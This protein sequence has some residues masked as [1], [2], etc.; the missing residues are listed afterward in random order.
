MVSFAFTGGK[1]GVGKS[2]LATNVALSLCQAG[3]RA[4]L[5]DADLQL[6][7]LDVMLGCTPSYNLQ[8]VVS[9]QMSLKEILHD[10]PLGL[11]LVSGGSALNGL[12]NAG[13]K[14]MATFLTQLAD[15]SSV[16]DFL[17]FDTGAGVDNRVMTFL[18]LAN[19]VV[20]VTTPDP[21][22]VTDAYATAKVLLKKEPSAKIGVLV[23]FVRN[24]QEAHGVFST[25]NAI[26]RQFLD[27]ELS[28]WG[29]VRADL[30]AIESVRQRRPVVLAQPITEASQ[31]I[32]RVA[33]AMMARRAKSAA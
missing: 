12:M 19:E 1:G 22:S 9:Q 10:G 4:V 8:H 21:T 18:R 2:I 25:L 13:P 5:F 33:Q 30:A 15:L 11:K 20:L 24:E 7:N 3:R 32:Q 14:R 16:A 6:A 17:I 31:D 23:N 29:Y 28:Y 26:T 27:R